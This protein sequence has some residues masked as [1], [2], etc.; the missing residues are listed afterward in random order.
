MAKTD[1]TPKRQDEIIDYSMVA[2]VSDVV[3]ISEVRLVKSQCFQTPAAASSKHLLDIQCRTRVE[4][5]RKNSSI[6]VFLDFRL[7]GFPTEGNRKEPNLMIEATFILIYKATKLR[8]LKKEN[9]QAFADTNGVY[10]AW[11]YCREF[12][13]NTVVRMG[14]PP[15]TIPVFRLITPAKAKAMATKT[16]KSKQQKNA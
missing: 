7:M 11:P 5:D 16:K 10:N 13:Q 8:G 4:V 9:F 15:L 12:V 6:L 3:Q 2:A 1:I 14:L